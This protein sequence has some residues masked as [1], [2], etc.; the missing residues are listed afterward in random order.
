M[1]PAD[2]ASP[3]TTRDLPSDEIEV[4]EVPASDTRQVFAAMRELRTDFKEEGAFVTF[5]N[6]VLRPEGYR[7]V[8]V[9]EPPAVDAVSVAGF[10]VSHM[11]SRGRFLYVDDLSTMSSARRRGHGAR[12]MAWLLEE[13][14]RLDCA[15][16]HLDSGVGPDRLAAHRLYFNSGM[17]ISAYHFSRRVVEGGAPS[18]HDR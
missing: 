8:A 7:L 5:V 3:R 18:V 14:R 12:L 11:L 9:Y 4:R 2:P 15:R 16:L 1:A 13:A 6:D 10:H 17:R